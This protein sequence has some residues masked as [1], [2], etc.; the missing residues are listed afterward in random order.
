MKIVLNMI[1]TQNHFES[2]I[3]CFLLFFVFRYEIRFS[4]CK[5]V[6]SD[7]W[8]ITM[9]L[10]FFLCASRISFT[11]NN[12]VC[13]S[14]KP[15]QREYLMTSLIDVHLW[16]TP[17]IQRSNWCST[18]CKCPRK[19]CIDCCVITQKTSA[20]CNSSSIRSIFRESTSFC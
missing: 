1:D 11:K 2:L 20:K 13:S 19:R 8:R 17:P 4:L 7:N 6:L 10:Y 9:F 16:F 5:G 12:L 3:M 14:L 15:T 18:M